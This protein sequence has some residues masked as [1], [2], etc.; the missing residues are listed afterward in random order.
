ML[1]DRLKQIRKEKGLTQQALAA[2]LGTSASYVSDI[3]KGK[4]MPGSEFLITLK[5]NLGL[6]I[7]WLLAG[8]G[9]PY[10]KEDQDAMIQDGAISLQQKIEAKHMALV[11][12][13]LDK[14]MAVEINEDLL[15]I[16][17]GS[18]AAFRETAVYIKGVASTVKTVAKEK[19]GK[20]R[21]AAKQKKKKA[22]G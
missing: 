22:N 13:F 10:V 12:G 2:V 1:G 18:A 21:P 8:E 16:E 3:E 15:T 4:K 9:H 11:K 20:A 17:K 6:N 5:R 7:D 19:L 14:E